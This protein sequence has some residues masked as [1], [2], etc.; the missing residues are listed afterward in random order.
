MPSPLSQAGAARQ[1]TGM[2]GRK[3]KERRLEFNIEVFR[4]LSWVT[5]GSAPTWA[6]GALEDLRESFFL[7]AGGVFNQMGCR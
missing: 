6:C 5:G 2:C 4:V 7:L 3:G 1:W